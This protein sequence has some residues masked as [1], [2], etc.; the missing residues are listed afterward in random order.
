MAEIDTKNIQN[1]IEFI[2][3]WNLS[4]SINQVQITDFDEA[5]RQLNKPY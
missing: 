1:K 3:Y 2:P 5:K 4:E